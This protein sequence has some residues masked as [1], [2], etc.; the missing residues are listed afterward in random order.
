M[1]LNG[2]RFPAGTRVPAGV[3][4]INL[5]PLGHDPQNNLVSHD[6]AYTVEQACDGPAGNVL[7][8]LHETRPAV[9]LIEMYPFGRRRF[10]FELVPLLDAAHSMAEDRPRVVCSL[11]DILVQRP[12]AR[13]STTSGR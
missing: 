12:A 8:A 5:P 7:A 3:S 2:G 11:R 13:R 1:L 9:V 4:V 10:E 6:P